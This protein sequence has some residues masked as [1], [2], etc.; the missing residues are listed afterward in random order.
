MNQKLTDVSVD[1]LSSTPILLAD[2]LEKVNSL[3]FDKGLGGML[4]CSLS[5]S[6]ANTHDEKKTTIALVLRSPSEPI[7]NLLKTSGAFFTKLKYL[8]KTN[9]TIFYEILSKMHELRYGEGKGAIEEKRKTQVLLSLQVSTLTNSEILLN[10]INFNEDE[11]TAEYLDCWLCFQSDKKESALRACHHV[12]CRE[13]WKEWQT[14]GDVI[15]CPL[16]SVIE[17]DTLHQFKVLP[18]KKLK[19]WDQWEALDCFKRYYSFLKTFF[20]ED[21]FLLV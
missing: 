1:S 2:K 7:A 12:V 17:E 4:G 6:A 19:A 20:S 11:D 21:D 3:L 13:C 9:F 16:C 8:S 14:M 15:E 18:T 10:D 5:I